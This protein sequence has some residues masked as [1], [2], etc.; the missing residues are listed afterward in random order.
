[1][2]LP[3]DLASINIARGRDTGVPSLNEARREFFAI[4]QDAQLAPYTSWV[5]FAAHLKHAESAIN[6]IAAYGT[7]P[8]ITSAATTA[9]KR[10]AALA[11]VTGEG[12]TGTEEDRLAFLNGPA[13]STGVDD[14]DL[15][16][17]GLAEKQMPFGGLLGSTLNFVFETQLEKLQNGDPFYYLSRTASLDFAA[18]LENNSFAKLIMLNT[19]M[20]HLPADVFSTPTHILEVDSSKQFTGLGGDGRADPTG[21]SDL[22]PLVIRDN[23][24]TPGTDTNY[25]RYTGPDHAVLGSTAGND[26]M[27]ASIGDDTI[28]G[29]SGNDR[30][31]GGGGVDNVFGGDGDD[32]FIYTIG[33]GADGVNGGADFDTLKVSGTGG[34]DTLDVLFNGTLL[35]SLEGGALANL[36]S[37]TA[38]LLGGIDTLSYAGTTN[39]DVTANLTTGTASGFTS[40]ANIENL[41]GGN[42]H[43]TLTGDGLVNVLTGGTGDDTLSGAA[44]DDT[45]IYTIGHGADTVDGGAD[46]DT[47]NITGTAAANTLD[48]VFNGTALTNFEGGTVA[49]VEAVTA[50]LGGGIDTVNYGATTASVTV[51]LA[52]GTASGFTLITNIENVTGG[53]GNDTLTGDANANTL[54]G[55]AGN[56][57][58][59]GGV[60]NDTLNGGAGNDILHITAG[61]DI[62]HITAGNDVFVFEVPSFDST[63]NGFDANPVGGQDLLDISARGIT[64]ATFATAVNITAEGTG[65]MIDFGDPA[66]AHFHLVDVNAAAITAADFILAS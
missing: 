40:L 39:I 19:D 20:T 15:W 28:Y 26:T 62:L 53:V 55:G 66:V 13:A 22:I 29:D 51:D 59:K 6:F 61:N 21:D 64:T 16:I 1:V 58:L 2:G 7:H 27:I 65:T 33:D 18:S 12:F 41:I 60:G 32:T 52:T 45:F 5:D 37:I 11:I 8:S 63:I 10:A 44:G 35:L 31:D 24:G 36:E 50:N 57:V 46:S 9:D 4:T 38:D 56:D 30:I 49:N 43:D 42:G 3:L 25:L 14:I 47:L 17:G 34:N 23:P 54:N 48:V